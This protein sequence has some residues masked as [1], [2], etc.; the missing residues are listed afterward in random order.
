MTH[1]GYF[2]GDLDLRELVGHDGRWFVLLSDLTYMDV[3]PQ[4]GVE[5]WRWTA[6]AG[7]LTDFASIPRP[8]WAFFPPHGKHTRAAVIHDDLCA[9]GHLG[10]SPLDSREVHD[11]FKRMLESCGCA[12][13]TVRVLW[14]GVRKGGPRFD[15][16]AIGV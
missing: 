8:F 7:T 5:R 14:Q 16:A 15:A 13:W 9:L 11:L 3:D 10:M 1:R 2:L 6:H 12:W 4:T